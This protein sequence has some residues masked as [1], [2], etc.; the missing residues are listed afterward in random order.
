MPAAASIVVPPPDINTPRMR[1]ALVLSLAAQVGAALPHLIFNLIDDFG[2]K[3]G[4]MVGRPPW[5]EVLAG[6]TWLPHHHRL[7]GQPATDGGGAPPPPTTILTQCTACI[8]LFLALLPCPSSS[9]Y[10]PAHS[11]SSRYRPAH[12]YFSHLC[13]ANCSSSRLCPAHRSSSRHRP[14]HRGAEQGALR[15]SCLVTYC[16][17]VPP[18]HHPTPHSYAPPHTHPH[19]CVPTVHLSPPYLPPPIPNPQGPTSA[20]TGRQVSTR[21]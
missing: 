12:C 20:I 5:H 21:P 18:P 16:L 14:A 6:Y 7:G 10:C 9:R 3:S 4:R 15:V 13:P 2:C 19:S 8:A 17:P 1:T 11:S